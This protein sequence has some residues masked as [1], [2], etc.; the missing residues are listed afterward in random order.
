MLR[1]AV[2]RVAVGFSVG[3]RRFFFIGGWKKG[4]LDT[5]TNG[6]G[7]NRDNG[8]IADVFSAAAGFHANVWCLKPQIN[9][10]RDPSSVAVSCSKNKGGLRGGPGFVVVVRPSVS[11]KT[12]TFRIAKKGQVA[13]KK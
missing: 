12:R 4:H 10:N 9:G 11:G 8:A 5:D 1:R 7:K 13:K 2:S 6:R 3:A